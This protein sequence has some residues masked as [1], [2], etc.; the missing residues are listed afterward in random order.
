MKVFTNSDFSSDQ[1]GSTKQR[2]IASGIGGLDNLQTATQT[3]GS[4]SRTLSAKLYNL[5]IWNGVTSVPAP[6]YPNLK[7]GTTFL[8]SDT[9]KLY[10]WDGTDTW[11]EV[12]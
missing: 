5:Q 11:N 3:V 2:T 1:F 7:N 9:N 10:M 6:V 4:S 8:T 12:S